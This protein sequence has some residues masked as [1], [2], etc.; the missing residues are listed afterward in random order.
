MRKGLVLVCL[1]ALAAT[2]SAAEVYRWVD[3][4]GVIHYSDT[5][6]P[7][8]DKVILAEPAPAPPVRSLAAGKLPAPA[9][10][11]GQRP[12]GFDYEQLAFA[13]PAA[14]E[15]L[16]NIEGQL[17]VRL[18]L[19]PALRPGDRVR[20]YL[21]GKPREAQGLQFRLDEVYRGTHNLQAEV[22]NEAGQLMIRSEP[23]RFFVQ[24]TSIVQP[25]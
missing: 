10:R 11:A 16:W 22:L 20:V 19:Q 9:E 13:Q 23:I 8:A 7:G 24:Q 18:S 15:T 6:H 2:G 14:E 3:E 5:P 21:D 4:D 12:A 1:S 17:T 25:H